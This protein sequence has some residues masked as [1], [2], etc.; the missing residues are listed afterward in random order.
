MSRLVVFGDSNTYGHGLEDCFHPP[1][2]SYGPNPS[3]FAW[4]VHL[5][6]LLNKELIHSADTCMPGSGN[7]EILYKILYF[8]FKP[9]DVVVT[10]W[11]FAARDL[12]LNKECMNTDGDT[13]F[14]KHSLQRLA[15]YFTEYNNVGH[16]LNL[17]S[18]FDFHVRSWFYAHHAD[19][20]LEL[21]KIKN[22]NF[23]LDRVNMVD[24]FF[25]TFLNFKNAYPDIHFVAHDKALDGVH[26]GPQ[27]HITMAN[28]I[29]D[30]IK[31]KL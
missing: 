29:N 3:K 14:E 10:L 25:P 1:T 8:K 27:S 2:N 30:I 12:L 31:N 26:P 28:M 9:D 21:N 16:W 4:P 11:S 6:K 15:P 7:L 24:N 20:Y 17:Y 23:F 22:F 5:S 13:P 19:C 18:D